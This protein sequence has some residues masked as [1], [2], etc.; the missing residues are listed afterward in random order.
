MMG[1]I[2]KVFIEGLEALLARAHVQSCKECRKKYEE[3][4]KHAKEEFEKREA[5][6]D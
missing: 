5:A 4:I 6:K 2:D 1:L 3:I